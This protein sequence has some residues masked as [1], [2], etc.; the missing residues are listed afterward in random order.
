MGSTLLRPDPTVGGEQRERCVVTDK[1]GGGGR[2]VAVGGVGLRLGATVAITAVLFHRLSFIRP[3]KLLKE[4]LSDCCWYAARK[5][6]SVSV[7]ESIALLSCA[8]RGGKEPDPSNK[9]L[10]Q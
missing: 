9:E 7:S 3:D 4:L 5:Q 1:I 6:P 10:Q 8:G 2:G